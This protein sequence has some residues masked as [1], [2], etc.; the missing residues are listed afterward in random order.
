MELIRCEISSKIEENLANALLL[1]LKAMNLLGPSVDVKQKMIDKSKLDREKERIRVRSN[2]ILGE[3][4]EK[5]LCIDVDRKVDK[6]TLMYKEIEDEHGEIKLK[7][8]KTQEHHLTFTNEEASEGGTYLTQRV[9]PIK[10]ATR[11]VLAEEVASV[12]EEFNSLDKIKTVLID[13]ANTST[14]F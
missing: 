8:E 4:V 12:L 6:G 2:E 10:G 3:G 7:K 5:L 14:G 9:I 11:A 13:N 1:D